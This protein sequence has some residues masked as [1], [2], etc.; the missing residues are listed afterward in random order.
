MQFIEVVVVLIAVARADERE[1]VLTDDDAATLLEE[2][3]H[4]VGGIELVGI[5]AGLVVVQESA[6]GHAVGPREVLDVEVEVADEE[7]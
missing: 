4:G 5:L 6:D 1:V 2:H 7:V 3:L